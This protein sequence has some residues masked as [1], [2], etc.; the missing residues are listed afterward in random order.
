MFSGEIM[1]KLIVKAKFSKVLEKIDTSN[2]GTED[3]IRAALKYLGKQG[4]SLAF[5]L[6]F[7]LNVTH[8]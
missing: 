2:L 8:R 4:V 3:I 5:L 6:H 7:N 1:R